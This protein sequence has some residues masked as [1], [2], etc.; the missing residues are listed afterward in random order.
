VIFA[1]LVAV[2]YLIAPIILIWGWARWGRLPKLRTVPSMLSLTG[3]ILSTASA[4]LAGSAIA[5]ARAIHGFP[6]YDPLLLRIFRCGALLSLGGIGFG[7]AGVWRPSSLRWHA[8]VSGFCMLA[9]WIMAAE[10]E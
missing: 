7:V 9:F 10:G 2:G 8:P 1:L 5:Y 6:Y 4:A 3:F